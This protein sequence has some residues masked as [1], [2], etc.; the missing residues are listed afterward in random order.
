MLNVE[1]CRMSTFGKFFAE[2]LHLEMD[3][4]NVE[5][6]SILGKFLPSLN[7]RHRGFAES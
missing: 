5:N 1:N 6:F 2:C 4:P 3:L 7:I